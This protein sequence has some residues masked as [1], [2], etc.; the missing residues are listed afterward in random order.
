MAGARPASKIVCVGRNY[1]SFV[2]AGEERPP[3]EPTVF[4]KPSVVR[5]RAWRGDRDPARAPGASITRREVRAWSFASRHGASRLNRAADHILGL[6]ALERCHGARGRERQNDHQT[7]SAKAF[8]TF[9][10]VRSVH[11]GRSWTAGICRCAATSTATSGR[12][13]APASMIFTIPRS[14][15]SSR[16]S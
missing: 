16:R 6:V 15:S 3:D 4:I 1:K 9:G 14:W 13:R 8:D 5:R 2:A 10:P 12:T 11:R 7:R